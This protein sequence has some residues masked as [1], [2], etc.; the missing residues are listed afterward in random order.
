MLMVSLML[1]ILLL[2][3]GAAKFPCALRLAHKSSSKFFSSAKKTPEPETKSEGLGVYC[4]LSFL[5]LDSLAL[6]SC[7]VVN[8]IRYFIAWQAPASLVAWLL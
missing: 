2:G 6:S 3:A 8:Q 1:L 7:P 4:A 5:F